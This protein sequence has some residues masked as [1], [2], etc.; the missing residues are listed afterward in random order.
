MERALYDTSFVIIA[1]LLLGILLNLIYVLLCS[2]KLFFVRETIRE[3]DDLHKK[4]HKSKKYNVVEFVLDLMY[5][6]VVSPMVLVVLHN[7]NNGILRW[8][9]AISV[10]IGY[11]CSYFTVGKLLTMFLE[12]ISRLLYNII[13]KPILNNLR[14]IAKR[15]HLN[16]STKRKTGH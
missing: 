9:I 16:L 6:I 8:Y 13:I 11:M 3:D 1:S 5:F 4:T 10:L 15:I 14:R 2:F 7:L 12:K